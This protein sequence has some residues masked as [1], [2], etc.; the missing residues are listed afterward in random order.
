MIGEKELSVMKPDA[1]LVNT[2]RGK[3]VDEKALYNALTEKKIAGCGLDV[4]EQEPPAPDNPLP[5]LENAII[6][7]HAAWYSETSIRRLKEQGMDEI[8]RILNGKR[9][10]YAVNPE[11]LAASVD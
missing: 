8:V 11:V 7:P 2:C 1:V 10:R 3:V 5:G 9:P 6:T 4:L